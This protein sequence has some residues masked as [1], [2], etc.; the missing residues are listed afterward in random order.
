MIQYG[1]DLINIAG[2]TLS[3]RFKQADYDIDES[4]V[5]H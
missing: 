4:S 2:T 5:T 3:G 1:D